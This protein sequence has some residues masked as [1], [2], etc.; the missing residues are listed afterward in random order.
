[1]NK[2]SKIA[3]AILTCLGM[4]ACG[5]SSSE[6]AKEE[7]QKENSA[8]VITL[9]DTSVLEKNNLTVS[10]V[11]T[12]DGSIASYEW[13]QLTGDTLDFS[14]GDTTAISFTAPNVVSDTDVSFQLK[15]VDDQGA[16]ASAEITVTVEQIINSLS[17]NGSVVGNALAK[18]NITASIGEQEFSA[19]AD[20]SGKYTLDLSIDDDYTNNMVVLNAQGV[21]G[22]E[23]AELLS[24]L[25]TAENLLTVSG[26]DNVL[27]STEYF[28]TNISNI[29][30]AKSALILRETANNL[31][32]SDQQINDIVMS[33][34]AT[35]MVYLAIA[36]KV[37]IDNEGADAT[38]NVPEGF[39]TTLALAKDA[40][41]SKYFVQ[42]I[43]PNN[44]FSETAAAIQK[45]TQEVS[46]ELTELP[47][48]YY[49]PSWAS[50][51][52][53]YEEAEGDFY[54]NNNVLVYKW[55]QL[56]DGFVLNF[57][58]GSVLR[59]G[60]EN[61]NVNGEWKT[62]ESQ[63]VV[64]KQEYY[65]IHESAGVAT[66]R[67]EEQATSHFPNGESADQPHTASYILQGVALNKLVNFNAPE[68][69]SSYSLPVS[70]SV[71]AGKGIDLIKS[72]EFTFNADGSGVTK[73]LAANFTWQQT[74]NELIDD[75]KNIEITMETGEVLL[76]SQL[77]SDEQ[78]Q[79]Y[80]LYA[81]H[82]NFDEKISDSMS[83]TIG[84]GNK[85]NQALSFDIADIPGIYNLYPDA[86][87]LEG[88]PWLELWPTGEA[89]SVYS[90]DA[91]RD[92]QLTE[93][94]IT[95][96][97]GSWAVSEAGNLSISLW[98]NSGENT[99]PGCFNGNSG[100][101]L[102]NERTVQLNGHVNNTL[103]VTN[104][105]QFDFDENGVFDH[106]QIRNTKVIKG[107]SRP[108]TA[109]Y[110]RSSHLPE[111]SPLSVANLLPVTDFINT[112]YHGISLD[113]ITSDEPIST[114]SFND[115]LEFTLEN[116]NMSSQSTY[117]RFNNEVL[118]LADFMEAFAFITQSN[119]VILSALGD[120]IWPLFTS[121]EEATSF[122]QSVKT[123][124]PASSFEALQDKALFW[125]QNAENSTQ[126]E[127]V[128]F[129]FHANGAFNIYEDDTF[130]DIV[131]TM[132]YELQADGSIKG[133]STD[134]EEFEVFISL[135]TDSFTLLT[136]NFEDSSEPEFMIALTDKALATTIVN[137]FNYV[138]YEHGAQ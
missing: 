75:V 58:D 34:N 42:Q 43:K 90:F 10:A 79:Y 37:I 87:L 122:T 35:D 62:V 107:Q 83:G 7:T 128:H 57:N 44:V 48:G 89:Y 68:D 13:T 56:G 98:K 36:L 133:T 12:D 134:G 82:D 17:I 132:T 106:K 63:Y 84:S 125:I 123:K 138:E 86:S 95:V 54:S 115:S 4:A 76:Y 20:E 118:L 130:T 28:D 23:Y 77:T 50:Y 59:S 65:L 137:A 113:S 124:A 112:V 6:K 45:D 104:T 103:F 74:D 31:K 61:I 8:P 46:N 135:A 64:N 99:Q 22:N 24:I 33:L 119:G 71:F 55:E 114:L 15:V 66:F 32:M 101:Y 80:V 94:E 117:Q 53:F 127:V 29:T 25:G 92:G 100:C 27:D 70:S 120:E 102:Y 40:T 47:E 41:A 108:L 129:K 81:E 126:K 136:A 11:V 116:E 14:G 38:L 85:V 91:D 19:Q 30:T 1:M 88:M 49:L 69:G 93:N 18:A 121:E 9:T 2:K 105:H 16:E 111:M 52:H 110:G 51:F 26:D 39:A 78:N 5:G 3:L 96:D 97:Y 131:E 109:K 73:A 21:E 72:E 60:F 67:V